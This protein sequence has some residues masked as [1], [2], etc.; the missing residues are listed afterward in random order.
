M[1][2]QRKRKRKALVSDTALSVGK[3]QAIGGYKEV[4]AEIREEMLRS[5]KKI[6]RYSKCG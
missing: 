6:L 2:V 3:E 5:K 1:Y 4:K